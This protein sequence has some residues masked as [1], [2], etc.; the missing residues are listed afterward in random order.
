[1]QR[2][3]D[4]RSFEDLI[5]MRHNFTLGN[6]VVQ[7]DFSVSRYV[8][9]VFQDQNLKAGQLVRRSLLFE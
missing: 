8:K 3:Q 5:S 4:Y 2:R 9:Q 1:M 7:L 6:K